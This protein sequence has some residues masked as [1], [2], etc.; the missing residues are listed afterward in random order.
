MFVMLICAAACTNDDLDDATIQGNECIDAN[1]SKNTSNIGIKTT[2][3]VGEWAFSDTVG[4]CVPSGIEKVELMSDGKLFFDFLDDELGKTLQ[5]TYKIKRY[6]VAE[7]VEKTYVF[8]Y[9][10]NTD[11]IIIWLYQD[12][13]IAGVDMYSIDEKQAINEYIT[14]FGGLNNIVDVQ[15]KLIEIVPETLG[16]IIEAIDEQ[17]DSHPLYLH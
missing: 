7:K 8:D 6:Q 2:I 3:T 4:K 10:N 12:K 1:D 11:K 15:L 16:G 5:S 14:D 13:T 17:G 9:G